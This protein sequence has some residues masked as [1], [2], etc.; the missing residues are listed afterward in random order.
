MGVSLRFLGWFWE[1][2]NGTE[3][4]KLAYRDLSGVEMNIA[5]EQRTTEPSSIALSL[6]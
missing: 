1:S 6:S 3:N 5:K 2:L 4:E